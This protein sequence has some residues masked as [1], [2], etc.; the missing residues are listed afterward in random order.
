MNADTIARSAEIARAFGVTKL[1]LFGSAAE[2]PATARDIDFACEGLTGWDLF[3]F[4]ARLGEELGKHVD[5]IALQPGDAF[6]DCVVEK[7][8]TVYELERTQA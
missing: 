5:V 1:V 2:S 3:R 7:G 4:G 6:S 8:R